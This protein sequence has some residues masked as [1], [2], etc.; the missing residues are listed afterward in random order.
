MGWMRAPDV[1]N[2]GAAMEMWGQAHAGLETLEARGLLDTVYA[3]F[4]ERPRPERLPRLGRV[5]TQE[6]LRWLGA[7]FA[8]RRIRALANRG[9]AS[10][11]REY[12][13]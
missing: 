4:W 3:D 10:R 11:A 8:S 9:A 1:E 12:Q 6:R 5:D 7:R 2:G 13:T